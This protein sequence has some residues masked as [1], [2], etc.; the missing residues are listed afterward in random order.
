MAGPSVIE[1]CAGAG[2]QALGLEQAGFVHRLAI[3]IDPQAAAT[4][5]ANLGAER[6]REGDVA[7]PAVW[8]PEEY[9][10]GIDLLAGGVPCP[11][12]SLA[13]RQLGAADERD[14]FAW[15]V[16]AAGVMRPRAIMLE[17]VR[18]LSMRRFSGYR[19]HVL[20]RLRA[21]G[22]VADWRLLHSSDYGVPQLRPR[23]VL[24]A[25]HEAEAP[26]FRWPEPQPLTETVGS[27]LHQYMAANGWQ[28][29][30]A[31]SELATG[32]APTIVGGSKRHGGADLGPT[33]AKA[34][35]RQLLVDGMGIADAP[36]APFAPHP[37]IKAPR[38]T[39]PMV[40]RLQGWDSND[41]AHQAWIENLSGRKT[42]QYRQ[43]GNAFPPPVARALALAIRAALDHQGT[44]Q[45]IADSADVHDAVYIALRDANQP[46]TLQQLMAEPTITCSPAELERRLEHLSRDF[47]LEIEQTTSGPAFRL[48]N[49][50]AFVGQATHARHDFL[51][52]HRSKV[53]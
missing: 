29:A 13:G 3:E 21:L 39:V 34:A 52:E 44:P 42:A 16:E 8:A 38:L 32:I 14:L 28:H 46:L 10:D 43:V 11:P 50:M 33:R 6:V 9:T 45:R 5:R 35:W 7:N 25:L 49:F 2:G 47:S 18:G 41:S 31:W 24:I 48:G 53:S 27:A 37:Q 12:F 23:F 51:A 15:A 19:Q 30:D 17:N 20:E 40:A 22:Y 4:L 26:F 36:P 1:I